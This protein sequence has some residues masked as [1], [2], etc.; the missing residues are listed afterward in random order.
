MS[1]ETA[2]PAIFNREGRIITTSRDV[3]DY[4]GKNHRDV[5]R[6]IDDL[7]EESVECARNF[8]QTLESVPM[9]RGGSRQDRVYE[10][11]RDGFTRLVMDFT[12][13]KARQFKLAYRVTAFSAVSL[14][15]SAREQTDL[16]R[17]RPE[18][19]DKPVLEF[20]DSLDLA[21]PER[22]HF[23]VSSLEGG[24]IRL[25]RGRHCW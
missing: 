18:E 24:Q 16:T 12:G 17:R 13:A 23:P 14:V 19:P 2:T 15:F 7:T 6:T 21:F 4:F 25:C 22:E 20:F 3:A 5:L 11:D 1:Q 8:A 9:P 10:M